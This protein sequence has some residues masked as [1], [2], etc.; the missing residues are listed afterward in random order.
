MD[1]VGPKRFRQVLSSA[2]VVELDAFGDAMDDNSGED[3]ADDPWM[4]TDFIG[5]K[6]TGEVASEARALRGVLD[7]GLLFVTSPSVW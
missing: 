6:Q 5:D 1:V 7:I 4:A 3:S 2:N